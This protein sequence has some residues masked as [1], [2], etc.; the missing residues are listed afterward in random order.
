[1]VTPVLEKWDPLEQ[2]G[3][4]LILKN[5]LE[6]PKWPFN[7]QR[8]MAEL[9]NTMIKYVLLKLRISLASRNEHQPFIYF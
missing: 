5:R 1:M 6:W 4:I 2:D 3:V 9:S 7:N 8:T